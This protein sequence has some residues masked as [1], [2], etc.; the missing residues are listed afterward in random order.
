MKNRGVF[1]TSPRLPGMA[2]KVG[3][4]PETLAGQIAAQIEPR[5]QADIARAAPEI[6]EVSA[7]ALLSGE[8]SEREQSGATAPSTKRKYSLSLRIE[9]ELVAGCE[10]VLQSYPASDH[11][12]IRRG[13]AGMV[14]ETLA[15]NPPASPSRKQS[16]L[17]HTTVR[18]DLRL[19]PDIVQ[20]LARVNDPYGLMPLT[21]M[22][23]R[24]VEPVYA[25]VLRNLL[26]RA[27]NTPT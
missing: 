20:A 26:S 18:L 11:A 8:T 14:R 27:A 23:A 16:Q 7:P 2:H 19:A 25:D 24:A 6:R 4:R 10:R 5:P 21:T 12:S 13:I 22:L 1:S 9:A 15:Q 17:A 3:G